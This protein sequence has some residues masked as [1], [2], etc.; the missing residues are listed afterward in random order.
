MPW[1]VDEFT[2]P[3]LAILGNQGRNPWVK[4]DPRRRLDGRGTIDPAKGRAWV[5]EKKAKML[6]DAT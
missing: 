5:D 1:Q 6:E 2:L 4:P 3:M